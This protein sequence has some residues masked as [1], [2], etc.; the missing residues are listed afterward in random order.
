MSDIKARRTKLGLARKDLAMKALVDPSVLQLLEL[1]LSED[2]ESRDK[3]E[4]WLTSEEQ[5]RGGGSN[6]RS[7]GEA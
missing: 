5:A 2:T 4:A 1:G 7:D 3:V 6:G